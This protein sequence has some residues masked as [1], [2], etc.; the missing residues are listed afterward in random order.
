MNATQMKARFNLIITNYNNLSTRSSCLPWFFGG[1]P[2]QAGL[3]RKQRAGDLS[4]LFASSLDKTT[5]FYHICKFYVDEYKSTIWASR[6]LDGIGNLIDQELNL[7]YSMQGITNATQARLSV[8][9]YENYRLS[10]IENVISNY[11]STQKYCP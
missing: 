4:F 2:G 5:I 6:L 11:E 9:R 7:G 3:D 10:E 8:E 1:N